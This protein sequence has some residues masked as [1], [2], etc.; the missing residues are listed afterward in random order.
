MSEGSNTGIVLDS[1]DGVS[2]TIP[3]VEG[4][5]QE[6]GV[7]SLKLAGKHVTE[8]LTK[9][10]QRRG[11][12]FNST[13]D[14]EI[15][16][17]MKEKLCY[18]SI[19]MARERKV[20]METCALDTEFEYTLPDGKK[21][22]CI[23]GKERFEAP[24]ILMQPHLF[25]NDFSDRAGL[26]RMVFESIRACQPDCQKPLAAHIVLSGGTSMIPGLSTRLENEVKLCYVNDPKLGKGDKSINKRVPVNVYDP[27][28]RKNAV[29]MGGSFIAGLAAEDL[30]I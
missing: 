24:E 4:H 11:Y 10:L 27:P 22:V 18:M 15:V 25:G 12:S 8:Y 2:H 5:I 30:Y 14:F 23:V 29:F 7:K 21:A 3:V 13:V 28:R 9:L 17:E 19:D 6:E 26:A 20:A 16:R 1:G